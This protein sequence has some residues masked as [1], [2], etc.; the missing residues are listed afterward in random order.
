MPVLQQDSAEEE[1]ILFRVDKSAQNDA[2]RGRK[3]EKIADTREPRNSRSIRGSR[4]PR[5]QVARVSAPRRRAMAAVLRYSK[6]EFLDVP[7]GSR[8]EKV[9]RSSTSDHVAS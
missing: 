6:R 8:S 7:D 3:R 9:G 1:I 4:T 5:C 2:S